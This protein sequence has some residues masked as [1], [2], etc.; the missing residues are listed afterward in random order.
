MRRKSNGTN[1]LRASFFLKEIQIRGTSIVWPMADIGRTIFISS[2]R[3]KVS[4]RVRSTSSLILLIITKLC[5]G[6]QKKVPS[7][8]M[9][10][11]L[12]TFPKCP[13]RIMIFLLLYTPK[14]K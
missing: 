8:W 7:P 11:K 9:R 6:A 3:M 14:R 1:S 13:W 4:L 2:F 12:M 5:L 10:P